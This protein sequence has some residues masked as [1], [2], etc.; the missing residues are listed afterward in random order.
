MK[1]LLPLDQLVES[2]DVCCFTG[3]RP[4]HIFSVHSYDPDRKADYQQI[5]EQLKPVIRAHCEAGCRT[6]LSGGAQGFDQL[7]FWAVHALKKEFPGLRNV[8]VKPFEGQERVWAK[9][10]LFS[11]Y[12][13]HQMEQHADVT[14][15]C[16]QLENQGRQEA[17]QALYYRN[18]V[19]IAL[20]SRLITMAHPDAAAAGKVSGGTG[21]CLREA[22]RRGR[23]CHIQWF[24]PDAGEEQTGLSGK[25]DP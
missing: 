2:P 7:A 1:P 6:F 25:M 18:G 8:L 20:S 5:I 3:P 9:T 16:A 11:Q 15:V 10:G 21:Q 4:S 12:Q 13:Y 22:Q 14:L 24:V 19:M 23:I 17:A